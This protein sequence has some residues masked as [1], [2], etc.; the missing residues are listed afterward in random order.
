MAR[1]YP[2]EN[3]WTGITR[4]VA[5]SI[6]PGGTFVGHQYPGIGRRAGTNTVYFLADPD[7]VVSESNESNNQKSFTYTIR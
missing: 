3:N 1:R 7:D 6:P 5:I 4:S 2:S